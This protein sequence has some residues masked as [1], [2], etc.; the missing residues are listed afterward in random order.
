MSIFY[1]KCIFLLEVYFLLKMLIFVDKLKGQNHVQTMHGTICYRMM[2]TRA[3]GTPCGSSYGRLKFWL[4]FFLI[5]LSFKWVFVIA[6]IFNRCMVQFPIIITNRQL[7]PRLVAGIM[8]IIICSR[9]GLSKNIMQICVTILWLFVIWLGCFRFL[10]FEWFGVDLCDSA[11]IC[12]SVWFF[13][14]F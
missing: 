6:T 9:K 11:D 14:V 12:G 2:W 8:A 5:F 1:G 10:W 7:L 13:V 3:S 4:L